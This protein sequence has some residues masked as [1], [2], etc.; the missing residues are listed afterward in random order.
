MGRER[1]E[2]GLR[3]VGGCVCSRVGTQVC[4][5]RW[6]PMQVKDPKRIKYAGRSG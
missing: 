6:D 2:H 1:E 5:S 3:R 4:R